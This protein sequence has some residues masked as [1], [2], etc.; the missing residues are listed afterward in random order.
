MQFFFFSTCFE[1]IMFIIR[2]TTLYMQPYMVFDLCLTVHHQWRKSKYGNQLDAAITVLLIS[3]ISSTCFGQTNAHLQ[4]HKTEIFY[5][6]IWYNFLGFRACCWA[7]RVWCECGC[8]TGVCKCL[9][10]QQDIIPYVC[11]KNLNLALLKMGIS[12]SETCWADL[13]DQ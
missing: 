8:F 13:G 12:L 10:H 5:T 6:N 7:L 3:K 11:I 4:E 2:K 1:H 9:P